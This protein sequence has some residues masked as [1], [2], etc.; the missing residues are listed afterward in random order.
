[1]GNFFWGRTILKF[2]HDL[3]VN[4]AICSW[5]YICIFPMFT[6][7][8]TVHWSY[9][10]IGNWFLLWSADFHPTPRQNFVVHKP[11]NHVLYIVPSKTKYH[12]N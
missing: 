11:N 6:Y 10:N 3:W 7:D 2:I 1:V 8:S 12:L 9:V 5:A 4:K